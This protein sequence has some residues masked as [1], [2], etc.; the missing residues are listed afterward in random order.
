MKKVTGYEMLGKRMKECRL[1]MGIS[2]EEAAG[3]LGVK[4]SMYLS[5]EAGQRDIR[6]RKLLMLSRLFHVSCDYLLGATDLKTSPFDE[7]T[8]SE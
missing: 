4:T 7:G 5:Y 2:V 8:G 3:I 1:E 6:S